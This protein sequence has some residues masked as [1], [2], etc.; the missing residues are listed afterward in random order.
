MNECFHACPG[1]LDSECPNGKTCHSWL[2][3]SQSFVDPAM[4][5]VCGR[6]WAH[7][8]STCATRCFLGGDDTCPSGQTC[9][10]GVTECGDDLPPL[11]AVDA[12]LEEKSY[13]V[14]EIQA[15]LDEE[16]ANE[17]DE[18]AMEDSSNWWCGSSW[19]DMLENCSKRCASDE[20][21]KPNAWTDGQCFRTTGGPE[22]C[23]TPGVGV[24]AATPE[25]SKWC[26]RTW[27][28]M[29]E[30]CDKECESDDDCGPGRTCWVGPDT[31]QYVGVPVK[32]RSDPAS[33]W[34]GVD[35]DDAMTS[36]VKACPGEGD[37]ECPDGMSCFSG[38]S[39]T[40]EG[41]EIVREGYRCGETWED[42]SKKC[43]EECQRNS[44]CERD[45]SCFQQV[46]CESELEEAEGALSGK[47]CGKTWDSTG[48]NCNQRCEEDDDCPG[49]NQWCYWVE[50]T[51]DVDESAML[52]A[53]AEPTTEAPETS[54][55]AEVRRC[56]NGQYVG[57]A[58]QLN[59]DFYPCPADEGDD[60]QEAAEAEDGP[61]T[62]LSDWGSLPLEHAC[63]SDGTGNCG[64]CQ[65]DCNSDADCQPGLMCFSR[66]QGERTSVPGCVSGGVDDKPGMD[67]C[68]TPF[69]PEPPTTTTTTT[70]TTTSTTTTTTTTTAALVA[71]KSANFLSAAYVVGEL[72]YA[73]E[74][75]AND[76]CGACEGDCDRGSHC[77][78]GLECFSRD[79][80]SVELVPGCLGLGIAGMDYCYDPNAPII[81][82]PTSS[83][84]V[85][86]QPGCSAEVRACPGGNFIVYQDPDN[87]CEF[88]P[89]PVNVTPPPTPLPTPPPTTLQ[90]TPDGST[91]YCGY[92][93]GQVNNNCA[94]A[95]PCPAGSDN[96]CPGLEVCIRDSDCASILETMTTS[97]AGPM[98]AAMES[99]TDPCDD[100]CLDVLPSDW[101]PAETSELDLPNCLEVG[102]GRLCESDGE[103]GTDDALNNCGTYDIYAR[104]VCGGAVLSQGQKMRT[105]RPTGR[106]TDVP[107]PSPTTPPT[108]VATTGNPTESP[109]STP[110][111][112]PGAAITEMASSSSISIADAI[113]GADHNAA[114]ILQSLRSSQSPTSSPIQ[115]IESNVASPFTYDRSPGVKVKDE[116]TAVTEDDMKGPM[117]KGSL[118]WYNS[119]YSDDSPPKETDDAGWSFDSYFRGPAGRNS[120]TALTMSL[121]ATLS[122]MAWMVAAMVL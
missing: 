85:Q 25:G 72:D 38:S 119:G 2:T 6:N 100:L 36:C 10:G 40:E 67:Y 97:T 109:M 34:C 46:V 89:C 3:C 87:N 32:A 15:L 84:T 47:F 81:L 122:I 57:R 102:V 56:P 5:N 103:C 121:R 99:A 117:A 21:C 41:E 86:T 65:G 95:T 111:P 74:C 53:F 71:D 28:D 92:S 82:P 52:A 66:S 61:T 120:G 4:F 68:Y 91:S 1:G 63:S 29:L 48:E 44:D 77:A 16:I 55:N 112:T 79:I 9:F 30:T 22:N 59:C 51:G 58:Q 43:G 90:P 108:D 93:L 33:L 73:R 54:C 13:T 14:E 115:E 116:A 62:D 50:C 64:L 45:E 98:L 42:A 39:C 80:G 94:N 23:S 24:K 107:T 31:C 96:Q 20:D 35:Y 37:D 105:A 113:A 26:G 83:P 8:S 76:K 18:V 114:A 78:N 88:V 70:T 106:P 11:T 104:M 60:A 49:N 19:G 17:R 101:C 110:V 75:T 7:A 27:N 118:E 69:P 12:G